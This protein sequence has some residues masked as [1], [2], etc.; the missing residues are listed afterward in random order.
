MANKKIIMMMLSFGVSIADLAD[1]LVLNDDQVVDKLNDKMG[2][3]ESFEVML[4]IV[5]IAKRKD[6]A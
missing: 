5:E 3:K 6:R 4:A 2:Y 1:E